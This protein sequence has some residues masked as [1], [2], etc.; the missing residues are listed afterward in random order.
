MV[1]IVESLPEEG[2]VVLSQG[3]ESYTN[4]LCRDK[5]C[6]R[7]EMTSN[8]YTIKRRYLFPFEWSSRM[9]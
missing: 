5:I 4:R 3:L 7:S 6:S 1:F 8:Q 9:T 2:E